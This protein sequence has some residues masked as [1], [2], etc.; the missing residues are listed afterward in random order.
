MNDAV[1]RRPRTKRKSQNSRQSTAVHPKRC[2]Q[3]KS[4]SSNPE[5]AVFSLKNET[6]HK[7]APSLGTDWQHAAVCHFFG[8]YVQQSIENTPAYMDFLPKLYKRY[9]DVDY[10]R[11]AL[12]AVSIS[13]LANEKHNPSL[14]HRARQSFGRAI[15]LFNAV[16]NDVEEAKSDTALVTTFLISKYEV[17][18]WGITAVNR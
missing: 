6:E 12:V 18:E 2:D 5:L 8:N 16:L 4:S 13:G 17:S 10:F 3:L 11:A 7:V 1:R 14:L 15:T 9:S